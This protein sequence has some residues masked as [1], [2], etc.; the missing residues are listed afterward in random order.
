MGPYSPT[1]RLS[2][3]DDGRLLY[4]LLININIFYPLFALAMCHKII[5]IIM[6]FIVMHIAGIFRIPVCG[7]TPNAVT[8]TSNTILGEIWI[9]N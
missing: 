6:L 3:A 9:S 4:S 7:I 8:H 5:F 2:L 1:C